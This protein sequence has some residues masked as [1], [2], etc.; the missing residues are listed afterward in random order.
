MAT[1]PVME[2]PDR[3]RR[4]VHLVARYG[5]ASSKQI[6]LL[7]FHDVSQ[8]P[9]DR[10]LARLVASQYLTR[11][12]RR[13]V[14]GARGGSGQYVY[15]LGRRGSFM[16]YTGK[17][18]PPRSIRYH[19]LAIV[20]SVVTF[21][22]AEREGKLGIIGIASEPDAWRRIGRDELRPDLLVELDRRGRRVKLFVEVDMGSESQGQVR[23]KLE[24]YNRARDN[25]DAEV[26]PRFPLTL[27]VAVDSEREAELKWLVSQMPE[28]DRE[29][30]IVTTLSGLSDFLS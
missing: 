19:S 29:L 3:N 12:E 24:R 10:A 9:V 18:S 30:F 28:R 6:K 1:L 16:F 21:K 17:F 25:A 14:G 23:A 26:W 13:I 20:D 11:L 8:T 2:L 5:Q 27:W 15:G 22:E 7:L 4:I